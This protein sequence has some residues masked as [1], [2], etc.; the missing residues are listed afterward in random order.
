MNDIEYTDLLRL[1]TTDDF[2]SEFLKTNNIRGVPIKPQF[3]LYPYQVETLMWMRNREKESDNK[4]GISGGIVC[5]EMGMGKTFVALTHTLS[6][7]SE[8]GAP[9]LIVTS[10][11]IMLEWK[12]EGVEKF[13][14]S[15]NVLFF[16]NDFCNISSISSEEL[17]KYDIVITTYDMC[18]S[19]NK[20][21]KYYEDCFERWNSDKIISVKF[22][23]LQT[24]TK[25]V[26]IGI[27]YETVWERIICD[28]SQRFANHTSMT[29][30]CMM[31][32]CGKYRWCLSGTPIRNYD[33]DIWAQLRF[34]GYKTIDQASGWKR[35]ANVQY[36]EEGLDNF[37]YVMKY[38]DAGVILPEKIEHNCEVEMSEEQAQCYK[39]LHKESVELYNGMMSRSDNFT[40]VLV[41]LMRL[42]QC[43]IAPCL[44]TN[45]RDNLTMTENT[46]TPKIMKIIDIISSIPAGEK[47]C[48]FSS[49]TS[50]SDLV[51]S[52]IKKFLPTCKY[53]QLDGD[54]PIETRRHVLDT[55]KAD[56]SVLLMTYKVG[57]EGLNITEA[58]HCILGEPW[59]SLVVLEQ[60]KSR[61]WRSGQTKPVHIYNVI[62]KDTVEQRIIEVCNEK[63]TLVDS[64][65]SYPK[66]SKIS[67]DKYTIGRI[68]DIV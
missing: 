44:T 52:A 65:I 38:N 19:A 25:A 63:S 43:A 7:P 57:G 30:Y 51:A 48:F 28:E 67:I 37:V 26:G 34:C 21:K 3:T 62:S 68:I 64:Y 56:C 14:D 5:L 59:W 47:A 33:T 61:I 12:L 45:L 22:R 2:K 6:T 42:R 23:N 35:R 9:T 1:A 60:A 41:L 4:T 53:L 31:A 40:C 10:K 50:Y 15:V 27:L 49:F 20:Q 8:S 32:L 13:F 39:K 24:S 58:N 11:T 18:L 29:Y 17:L 36:K 16:H 66:H 55:F 54:T 46:Y